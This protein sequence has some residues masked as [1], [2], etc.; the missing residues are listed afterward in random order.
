MTSR[1]LQWNATFQRTPIAASTPRG[2]TTTATSVTIWL[3]RLV[4]GLTV[5]NVGA[6]AGSTG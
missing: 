3:M 2:G 1:S 6:A 5:A 4:R